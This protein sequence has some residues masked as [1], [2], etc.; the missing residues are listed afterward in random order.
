M[1]RAIEWLIV[2]LLP[3][4]AGY[5]IVAGF[6]GT[7]W[8]SERWRARRYQAEAPAEPIERIEARLCRLRAELDATET[9][10]VSRPRTY[11]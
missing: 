6:R 7:R 3:T 10:P 1:G 2:I 11:G 4:A 8:S 9:R 5:A